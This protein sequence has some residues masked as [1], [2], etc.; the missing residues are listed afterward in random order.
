MDNSKGEKREIFIG[1]NK[2]RKVDLI[3][4]FYI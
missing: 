3:C 2:K 1:G 4:L